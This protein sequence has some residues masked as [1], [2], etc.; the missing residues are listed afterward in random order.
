MVHQAAAAA[1]VGGVVDQGHPRLAQD[2]HRIPLA[3]GRQL[4]DTLA[5]VRIQGRLVVNVEAAPG[6]AVGV[7]QHHRHP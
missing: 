5:L 7:L 3:E 4:G 2:R 6:G 1:A